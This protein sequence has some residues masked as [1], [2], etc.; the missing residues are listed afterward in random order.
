[1]TRRQILK[2]Y[3]FKYMSNVNLDEKITGA[4]EKKFE[5]LVK[6]LK[7]HSE[8]DEKIIA[9]PKWKETLYRKF[10]GRRI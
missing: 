2:K 3:G 10:V 8:E 5:R 7:E 6:A 9:W 1:M 4:E